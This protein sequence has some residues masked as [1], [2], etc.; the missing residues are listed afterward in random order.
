MKEWRRQVWTL[1]IPPVKPHKIKRARIQGQGQGTSI[2]ALFYA[3]AFSIEPHLWALP[4][5][6]GVGFS[7]RSLRVNLRDAVPAVGD[8][9]HL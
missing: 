2:K 6:R 8:E 3:V 7:R 4:Q 5:I 9:G 1:T